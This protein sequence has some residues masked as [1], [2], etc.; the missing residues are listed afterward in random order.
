MTSRKE[1]QNTT[2]KREAQEMISRMEDQDSTS[3]DGSLGQHRSRGV[4]WHRSQMDEIKSI[5]GKDGL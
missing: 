2:S 5:L 1:A 3:R 4:Q